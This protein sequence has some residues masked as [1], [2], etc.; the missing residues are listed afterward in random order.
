MPNESSPGEPMTSTDERIHQALD[1]S[2]PPDWF[3]VGYKAFLVLA[4][5]PVVLMIPGIVGG[6]EEEILAAANRV[7]PLWLDGRRFGNRI[8]HPLRPAQVE[9][10]Q[11][12]EGRRNASIVRRMLRVTSLRQ[13]RKFW[14][15]RVGTLPPMAQHSHGATRSRASLWPKVT[16]CAADVILVGEGLLRLLQRPRR[17]E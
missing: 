16:L 12:I 10:R 6:S 9:S 17:L 4:F 8:R 5:V 15:Q 11:A 14:G 2:E 3:Y 7:P 1:S 13:A